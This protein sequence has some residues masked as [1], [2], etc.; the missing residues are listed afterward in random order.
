MTRVASLTSTPLTRADG[1][2]RVERGAGGDGVVVAP[3]QPGDAPGIGPERQ[4]GVERRPPVRRRAAHRRHH[5][6][7]RSALRAAPSR[8]MPCVCR[9]AAAA[10]S[11]AL[12]S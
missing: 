10:W 5:A 2:Q 7:S 4:F 9:G 11:M 6:S 12:A 1:E 3:P 8:W